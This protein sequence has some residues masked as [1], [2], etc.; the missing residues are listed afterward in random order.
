[1]SIGS[2]PIIKAG[3]NVMSNIERALQLQKVLDQL[4]A[5]QNNYLQSDDDVLETEKL[6]G[7]LF[8][9]Y[10]SYCQ[11]DGCNSKDPFAELIY[12]LQEAIAEYCTDDEDDEN[13]NKS[14]YFKMLVDDVTLA[15]KMLEQ[16]FDDIYY[17]RGGYAHAPAAILS[18][19]SGQV[20]Q[21]VSEDFEG[22]ADA[23]E[24]EEKFWQRAQAVE[25]KFYDLQRNLKPATR[26][27]STQFLT[28][29]RATKRTPAINTNGYTSR[30]MISAEVGAISAS[31]QSLDLA[32]LK[33]LDDIATN[34]RWHRNKGQKS[35][36]MEKLLRGHQVVRNQPKDITIT[37][38][39]QPSAGNL[40]NFFMKG[41]GKYGNNERTPRTHGILF[42]ID[43]LTDK[44]P[45]NEKK[46][47]SLLIK[48]AKDGEG[49][50]EQTLRNAGFNNLFHYAKDRNRQLDKL[51][52]LGMLFC[53]KEVSR[54]KQQGLKPDK[55]G[56]MQKMPE[57]PFG[58]A[59]AMLLILLRDGI[60]RMKDVFDE[61][62]EYGVFMGSNI[63]HDRKIEDTRQKFIKVLKL[64]TEIYHT[65]DE[66]I[67]LHEF[68]RGVLL[69][70]AEYFH[71]LFLKIDGGC[72]ES[73]GEEYVSSDDETL[74]L[75]P[76]PATP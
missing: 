69:P 23:D 50:N 68:P 12:S 59:R 74:A 39:Y 14:Q 4:E 36:N 22:F 15:F 72:D 32:T 26:Q 31:L 61:D 53:I 24:A 67:F 65:E 58:L 76:R 62:A 57:L 73:D 66:E 47:A 27:L 60:L 8:D 25:E 38:Q 43:G 1:M 70:T 56:R 16:K 44:K 63:M 75:Y 49:F 21:Y 13:L 51:N 3:N 64:F 28:S 48:F 45:V 10:K 2:I 55:T 29:R 18:S 40:G 11:I 46:L 37:S 9:V 20:R 41:I 33:T 34:T 19:K 52:K 54:R 7:E 30:A 42:I 35:W 6:S 71:K 17:E 5:V